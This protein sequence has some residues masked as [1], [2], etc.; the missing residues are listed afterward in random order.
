VSQLNVPAP[1]SAAGL[2][3]A[4]VALLALAAAAALILALLSLRD[5]VATDEGSG[6][7]PAPALVGE[8][9][10]ATRAF[11][12]SSGLVSDDERA[13]RAYQNGR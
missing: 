9:E 3:R 7:S 2:Q 5:S 13:T 1:R 6:G 4:A 12:N 11:M 10:G 8:A